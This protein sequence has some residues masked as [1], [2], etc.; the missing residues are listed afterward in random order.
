MV[1]LHGL[2]VD[3]EKV[4]GVR[5]IDFF[6]KIYPR[7]FAQMEG[8]PLNLIEMRSRLSGF[9]TQEAPRGPG[10]RDC[11]VPQPLW[12]EGRDFL[13]GELQ[14]LR[15][16]IHVADARIL[17]DC[18]GVD[19]YNRLFLDIRGVYDMLTQEGEPVPT[20][21]RLEMAK[22]ALGTGYGFPTNHYFVMYDLWEKFQEAIGQRRG[23]FS[24]EQEVRVTARRRH[25]SW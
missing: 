9:D 4:D 8:V 18:Y 12:R 23:G 21:T 3:Q 20:L 6:W 16:D 13:L 5:E 25:R 11:Q 24:T 22:K 1:D 19:I 17:G 7:S 14:L 2:F 10:R 15:G